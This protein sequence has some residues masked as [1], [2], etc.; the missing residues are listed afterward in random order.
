MRMSRVLASCL[1]ALC[2][3]A[4][5]QTYFC[6]AG[7][8]DALPPARIAACK[9]KLADVRSMVRGSGSPANWHYVMVCDEADW[10]S[11]AT[12]SGPAMKAAMLH[13]DERTDAHAR[14]TL[15]HGSALPAGDL[16]A[17][18]AVLKKAR[19][20]MVELIAEAGP[21]Q[22]STQPEDSLAVQAGQ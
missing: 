4:P 20:Q 17:V 9:A 19:Q 6:I 11:L 13:T 8:L 10:R 2:T 14:L 5:A 7:D 18:Q 16:R 3:I 22:P 15:F 12:L 21:A 1:F